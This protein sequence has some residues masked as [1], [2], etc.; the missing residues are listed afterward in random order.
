M[1]VLTRAICSMVC[2]PNRASGTCIVEWVAWLS[3]RS[4]SFFSTSTAA[5]NCAVVDVLMVRRGGRVSVCARVPGGVLAGV[6]E[7]TVLVPPVQK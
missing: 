2:E 4:S 1:T 3:I 5:R 7:A 6:C